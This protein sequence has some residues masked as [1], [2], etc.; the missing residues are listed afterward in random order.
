MK[1]S[2]F[3][4]ILIIFIASIPIINFFGLNAKVYDEVVN[5]SAIECINTSDEYSTVSTNK[6]KGL[7]RNSNSF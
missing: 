6:N 4:L 2:T 1:K 3:I 7:L 5:V